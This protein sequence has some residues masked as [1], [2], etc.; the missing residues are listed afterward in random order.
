M[1]G[2][3]LS[4]LSNGINPEKNGAAVV[5]QPPRTIDDIPGLGPIRLR[6]LRKAGLGS[7]VALQKASIE[8]LQSIRGL[9]EVKAKYILDYL[10]QFPNLKDIEEPKPN[11]KPTYSQDYIELRNAAILAL[12]GVNSLLLSPNAVNFRSRL[13]RE[14]G[15]FNITLT[16]LALDAAFLETKVREDTTNLLKVLERQM[17]DFHGIKEPD[18]KEQGAFADILTEVNNKMKVHC[19]SSSA[20]KKSDV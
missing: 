18:K 17:K 11:P 12:S 9:T 1:E 15:K 8:Q 2:I 5:L 13:M 14:L 19:L 3:E 20:A 10:A 7:L 4:V 16:A 6:A